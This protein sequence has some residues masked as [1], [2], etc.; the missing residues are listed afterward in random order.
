MRWCA[1]LLASCAERWATWCGR[2]GSLPQ[3][4]GGAIAFSPRSPRRRSQMRQA[5][6]VLPHHW[7]LL[8]PSPPRAGCSARPAA[9][10]VVGREAVLVRL[11]AALAQARQGVHQ[12]LF[13]TGEPGIG[14]TAVVEG[15]GAQLPTEPT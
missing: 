7:H 8:S 14:K 13:L 1:L 6:Q 5:L 3:C 15:F 2:R 4:P 9:T 12:F 11:H 10:P